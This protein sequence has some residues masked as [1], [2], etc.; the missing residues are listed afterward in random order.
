MDTATL[1]NMLH[2]PGLRLE[3]SQ[4]DC[5]ARYYGLLIDWNSRMNLTAITDWKDVC[6]KHFL[7]SLYLAAYMDLTGRKA[8]LDL[9]SGA[10]FPGIPLKIAFPELDVTL[11][12]SLNKRVGFMQAV[13]D[14]LGLDN[15]TEGIYDG[16]SIRAVHGR[17]EDMAAAGS[18]DIHSSRPQSG[19]TEP[20][21]GEKKSPRLRESFDIVVS[22]A[23]ANLSTLSE[24]CIPFVKM[25]GYFVAY[26]GGEPEE[27]ISGA[28]NA[29]S[30]LGGMIE[31]VETF[32]LPVIG[33]TVSG[34]KDDPDSPRSDKEDGMRRS[35][36]F[37]R[38]VRS[39]P[40]KY[41]RKAGLPSK[42]PL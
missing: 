26:K 29:I 15:K 41:P 10:G 9:G 39:T 33:D 19:T 28:A 6:V 2:F 1:K 22:R 3:Q 24:Y 12:D 27:E 35:L 31:R 7:D 36:I 5:F 17:A 23:V 38:K 25:D 34:S 37:I 13:I 14:E 30:L 42:E 4:Y 21:S 20:A 11:I 40:R 16:R 8:L 32:T 18:K